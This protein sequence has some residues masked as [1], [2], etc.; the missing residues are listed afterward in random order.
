MNEQEIL[1]LISDDRERMIILQAVSDLAL[2]D[3]WIGA[4]F[5]RNKVWDALFGYG[6]STKLNDVDV[7][8]WKSLSSYGL[9]KDQLIEKIQNEEENPV[10]DEENAYTERL[11]QQLPDVTFEVKNQ[12]RMHLWSKRGSERKPYHSAAEAMADWVETAT[13]IG[14][15]L[16]NT[17]SLILCATHGINDLVQ[18]I[19]RPVKPE[20]EALALE[21]ATTKGWLTLWPALRFEDA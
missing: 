10:W 19:I 16:D 20:L 21:R 2:D 3:W 12:A 13:A 9:S 7:V 11:T 17:G 8:Y 18:G 1:A 5:V 14:V 15:S 4:G 6:V